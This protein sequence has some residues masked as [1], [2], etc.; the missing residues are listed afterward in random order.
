MPES[1]SGDRNGDWMIEGWGV[2]PDIEV[3]NDPADLVHGKDVQLEKAISVLME[4]IG[5]DPPTLPERPAPLVDS[6]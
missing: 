1:G 4:E 5:S 6:P 2:E 3:D